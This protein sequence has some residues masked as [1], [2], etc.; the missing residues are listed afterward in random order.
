MSSE[1][2]VYNDGEFESVKFKHRRQGYVEGLEKMLSLGYSEVDLLHH[3]PA[4]VGHMT[5]WKAFTLY[6]LY[7]KT[8]GICGHIAEVG[9]DKAASTLLFAKLTQ[10]FEPEAL[11]LVHG[12]DWFRGVKITA[13]EKLI[14]ESTQGESEE[15][16]RALVAAQK[17]DHIV[18]IHNVDVA[19]EIEGFFEEHSHLRFKLVYLDCGLYPV[20]ASAIKAFWPRLVPGG[21]MVFDQ[22]SNEL[23]PGEAR[24]LDELLPGMKIETIPNSW[25]P[26]AFVQKPCLYAGV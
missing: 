12:F 15:R 10:I 16:V 9:V 1:K 3:F 6:E 11:T 24:A 7:K 5:L 14:N 26:N 22:Y 25:F 2:K 21:L 4:F 20:V 13:E 18:K 23:A 19:N 17:L 8:L